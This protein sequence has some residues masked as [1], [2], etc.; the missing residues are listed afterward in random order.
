MGTEGMVYL[1]SSLHGGVC[2][3]TVL[4]TNVIGGVLVLRDPFGWEKAVAMVLCVWGF[5]TY[6]YG[7]YSTMSAH[8]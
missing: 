4:T 2:M 7:E 5:S 3:A 8:I 1:T 6:M